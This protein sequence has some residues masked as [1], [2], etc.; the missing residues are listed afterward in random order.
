MKRNFSLTPTVSA[1]AVA[2]SSQTDA[3]LPIPDV[4]TP[5]P[6]VPIEEVAPVVVQALTP[7]GEPTFASL[8]LGGYSPVGILQSS[9]EYLH[10]SCDLPW[11]A[12][13][14][15][16]T[17]VIRMLLTPIV[18]KSQQ[19]AALMR[20]IMP[21]M[22]EIQNKITEARQM[23]NAVAYAEHNQELIAMMQ[24]KGVNPIK[25]LLVPMAQVPIFLSYFIGIRGMV[26]APVESLQT[27]GTLWFTDLTLADPYYLLPLITCS[28][29]ALTLKIASDARVQQVQMM[30]F[31]MNALP[32]ITFPFIMNFPS[33]LVLY[34]AS[35]NTISLMQVITK[36]NNF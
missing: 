32:I 12:T 17:F 2:A 26:N 35:S 24:S 29:L 4:P 9:L 34:W 1:S 28:T 16:S 25:N 22:Q 20:N 31:I 13:I 30:S 8:D 10:V 14:I 5:L 33:A 15:A 19:N 21:E 18:V 36:I 23:G 3:V 6:S 7:I 11:Y 27:G